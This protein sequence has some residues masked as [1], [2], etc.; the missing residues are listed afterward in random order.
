MKW[1]LLP[2]LVIA[3]LVSYTAATVPDNN[4][5]ISF[6]NVGEGDAVL[7]Q[8]GSQ[9]VLIDGGPSPQAIGLEL[10]QQMPFWDR[11]IDLLVLSA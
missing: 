6:L 10:G 3:V 8:K 9:Q 7:L 4:L 5:R 1:A 2:L 11:T